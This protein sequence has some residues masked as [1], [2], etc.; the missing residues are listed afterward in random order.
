MNEPSVSIMEVGPIGTNCYVL[1]CP[2]TGE[3][4]VIDPG[5]EPELISEG[6]SRIDKMVYTH[7]HFDHSGGAA[8]LVEKFSPVTMIHKEDAFLLSIAS[9]A[10]REWGFEVSQPPSANIELEEGDFIQCGKMS[11]SVIHTPGHSPGSICLYGHSMLFSGDTLFRGSIGRTDLPG[12]SDASMAA[13]LRKIAESVAPE[14]LVY[15]G[16]GP[17][18]DL[19]HELQGNPFLV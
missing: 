12:S 17:S 10:A 14:T 8:W 15:P 4:L 19:K 13:S 2:V 5:E 16:H 6:L 18:T 7:G 1:T 11:F 3:V 9:R